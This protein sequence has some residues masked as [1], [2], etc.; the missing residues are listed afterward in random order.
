KIGCKWVHSAECPEG[1]ARQLP[2]LDRRVMH[3]ALLGLLL[4]YDHW[5]IVNKKDNG[6]YVELIRNADILLALAKQARQETRTPTNALPF[7]VPHEATQPVLT[8]TSRLPESDDPVVREGRKML[9]QL[10]K[11][12]RDS[13]LV[14]QL[15]SPLKGDA[16]HSSRPSMEDVPLPVAAPLAPVV[17]VTKNNAV[18]ERSTSPEATPPPSAKIRVPPICPPQLV[19][20]NATQGNPTSRHHVD[21]NKGPLSGA[22]V[23]AAA[24]FA[25]QVSSTTEVS[26]AG[27]AE[28]KKR[29]SRMSEDEIVSMVLK[30]RKKIFPATAKTMSETAKK[31]SRRDAVMSFFRTT[32]PAKSKILSTLPINSPGTAG[33]SLTTTAAAAP[34][35]A[36]EKSAPLMPPRLNLTR[37]AK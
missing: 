20:I 32:S 19:D 36:P 25:R 2:E 11:T 15:K 14:K 8:T 9:A 35:A 7:D 31:A 21:A 34:A 23:D 28:M 33:A 22:D 10:Q 6:S 12:H 30:D 37:L 13:I 4:W 18:D 27:H 24:K 29:L 1:F 5:S 3:R 17:M 26:N 16:V